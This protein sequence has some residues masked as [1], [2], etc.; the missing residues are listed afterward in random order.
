MQPYEQPGWTPVPGPPPHESG[1]I[2]SVREV[3]SGPAGPVRI[4][5]RLIEP[6]Q[7]MAMRPQLTVSGPGIPQVRL[8]RVES[9]LERERWEHMAAQT[10]AAGKGRRRAVRPRGRQL[11]QALAAPD[12]FSRRWA[13][14][15]AVAG[16]PA[17]LRPRRV[18]MTRASYG[19]DARVSGRRYTLA[20]VWW[21][22]ARVTR[23]GRTVA[24]LRRPLAVSGGPRY[25]DAI[26]WTARADPVDVAMTH[27]L[28]SAYQ[29]GSPGFAVNLVAWI[30]EAIAR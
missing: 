7:L 30:L 14:S 20:Q 9:A 21:L 17:E 12:L 22:S 11:E 6:Y 4:E 16:S 10:A 26:S 18:L 29:V 13:V 28:A 24:R 19:V 27:A 1:E 5:L 8:D 23:D 3:A 25:A 15:L 2:W